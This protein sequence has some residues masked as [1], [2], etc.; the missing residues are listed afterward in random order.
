MAAEC[1]DQSGHRGL[2]FLPPQPSAWGEPETMKIFLCSPGTARLIER[3]DTHKFTST[4]ALEVEG[5][6]ARAPAEGEPPG[7]R[8]L[9][10]SLISSRHSLVRIV[11]LS[12]HRGAVVNVSP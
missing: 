9:F 8:S 12:F 1:A 3:L 5:Q 4:N 6:A 2:N 10:S 7:A 11:L